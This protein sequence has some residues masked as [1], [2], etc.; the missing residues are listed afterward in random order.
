MPPSDDALN[1]VTKWIWTATA[2]CGCIVAASWLPDQ[3]TLTEWAAVG[4]AVAQVPGPV[5]LCWPCP[6]GGR[7]PG[8]DAPMA[9]GGALTERDVRRWMADADVAQARLGEAPGTSHRRVLALGSSWLA[10]DAALRDAEAE[11]DKAIM[12]AMEA[13]ESRDR[14]RAALEKV[15]ELAPETSSRVLRDIECVRAHV[16]ESLRPT[17]KETP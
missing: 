5:S 15:Q 10:R 6:H 9:A 2:P 17:T 3:A 11:R 1:H 7:H 12:A 14:Y 4:W 13:E 16:R 8:S